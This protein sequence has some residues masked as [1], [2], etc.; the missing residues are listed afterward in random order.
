[1]T[2]LDQVEGLVASQLTHRH[3]SGLPA[4]GTVGDIR[5][6]FSKSDSR[7]LAVLVDGDRYVGSIGRDQLP[8]D[9]DPEAPATGLAKAG[10][11]ADPQ[12]A[13]AAARDLA[14]SEPSWRLPVVGADGVF[15]GVI[16]VDPDKGEFCGT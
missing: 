13:A 2:N 12:M 7:R 9:A 1:M 3:M 16:A 14:L 6:F 4:T 10:P 8:D 5:D 11:V 15:R